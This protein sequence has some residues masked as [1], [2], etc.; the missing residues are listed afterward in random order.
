M[1]DP[2]THAHNRRIEEQFTRQAIPFAQ[3]HSNDDSVR[4]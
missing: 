3:M 1:P 4:L 2:I